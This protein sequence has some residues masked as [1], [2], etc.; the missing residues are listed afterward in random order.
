MGAARFALTDR[1]GGSSR[2]TYAELNLG[3]HVGDAAADVTENRGRLAAQIGL[4]ADHVVYVNQVHGAGV[5]IV[6]G[7]WT[8]PV[9]EVDA[10]VTRAV[11]TGLAV[12]VADCVPVLL[13]DPGAGVVGVAHA[14]RRGMVAGVVQAVLAAMRELGASDVT[15][16][17]GP[18]VCGGCYEVPEQMRAA[19]AG[20]E[21]ASW[22]TTR[23]GTPALDVAAGVAAQLLRAGVEVRT[24]EGC[25][26]E[27]PT[28]YSYR[29][30]HT[31][32][33]FAGVAWLPGAGPA[34]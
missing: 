4:A 17:I 28:L 1:F 22:A 20:Q 15:A 34:P 25:T 26:V 21:P 5:A 14:G 23:A 6:D 7:P 24:L 30:D 11:G 31:T 18:S 3:G 12:L 2:G 8:G 16:R 10:M 27:D 19:V 32:G 13:A 9:P 29:R 33:R